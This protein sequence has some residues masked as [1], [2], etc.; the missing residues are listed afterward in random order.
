[1]KAPAIIP[2]TPFIIRELYQIDLIE[3]DAILQW[4]E[5]LEDAAGPLKKIKDAAQPF[6]NWLNEAETDEEEESDESDDE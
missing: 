6:I 5:T 2:K 4:F 1:L 3:E